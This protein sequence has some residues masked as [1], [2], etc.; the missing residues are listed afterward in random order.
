MK[1]TFEKYVNLGQWGTTVLSALALFAHFATPYLVEL[2]LGG[3]DNL[4]I[5]SQ[6]SSLEIATVERLHSHTRAGEVSTTNVA[7]FAVDDNDFEMHPRT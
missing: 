1:E 7:H 2:F 6:Y 4:G 5:V 3:I